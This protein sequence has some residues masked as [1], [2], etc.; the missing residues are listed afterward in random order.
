MCISVF[1]CLSV[2]ALFFDTPVSRRAAR[3]ILLFFTSIHF[4]SFVLDASQ[5]IAG[6]NA[7]SS[8]FPNTGLGTTI[9]GQTIKCNTVNYPGLCALN[10]I[11]VVLYY[12]LFECWSMCG[13]LYNNKVGDAE[14]DEPRKNRRDDGDEEDGESTKNPLQ[15]FDEDEDEE[16]RPRKGFK[17]LTPEQAAALD[18][19]SKKKSWC[20]IL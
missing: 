18:A 10:F 6:G 12:L 11:Q 4:A 3:T 14:D 8:K 7:C 17:K 15:E 1:G 16:G 5:S 9:G 20:P 19:Q 13:N 2:I